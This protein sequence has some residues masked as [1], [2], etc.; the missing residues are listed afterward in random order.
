MANS[1]SNQSVINPTAIE[2]MTK[3]ISA[4]KTKNSIQEKR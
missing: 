2:I 1:I 3:E 4:W